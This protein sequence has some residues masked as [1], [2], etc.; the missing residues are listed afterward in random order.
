MITQS[1]HEW[2]FLTRTPFV[3]AESRTR[4]TEVEIQSDIWQIC[5]SFY[6]FDAGM[7]VRASQNGISL[8]QSNILAGDYPFTTWWINLSVTHPLRTVDLCTTK[9]W[10]FYTLGIYLLVADWGMQL[11]GLSRSQMTV[12]DRWV[13]VFLR[14]EPF[15]QKLIYTRGVIVWS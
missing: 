5:L 12:L 15:N 1:P 2:L 3:F 4:K 10:Q 11:S 9:S 14:V 13:L 6:S 8:R 7:H